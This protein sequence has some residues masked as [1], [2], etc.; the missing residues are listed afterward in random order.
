MKKSTKKLLLYG[1]LVAGALYFAKKKGL[2]AG[3]GDAA[4]DAAAAEEAAY[5]AANPVSAPAPS[6][7]GYVPSADMAQELAQ[8]TS[9]YSAPS[10]QPGSASFVGPLQPAAGAQTVRTTTTQTAA[11]AKSGSSWGDAFKA[12][13]NPAKP[14]VA[15]PA[16]TSNTTTYVLI[17]AAV[18]GLGTLALTFGS[19]KK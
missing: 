14:A 1:G 17:G 19:K 11:P 12:L 16:K 4:S 10:S 2:L 15:T 8:Y 18:L 7:G 5:A 9:G 13:A 6:S 3:L